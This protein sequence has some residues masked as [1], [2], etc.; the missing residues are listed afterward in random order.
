[1]IVRVGLDLVEVERIAAAME[2]PA[3]VGR[4]LTP[5]ER[6]HIRTPL[7][8]AGRWAAKEAIAKAVG[9]HLSWQDVEILNAETGEPT[10]RVLHPDFD[11]ASFRIHLS[12]THEKGHAAAVAVLEELA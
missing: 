8:V 2:N 12:I 5:S 4:I 11:E 9:L 10:I 1:M 7:R 3:F 6:E